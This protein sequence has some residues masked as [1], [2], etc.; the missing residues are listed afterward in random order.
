MPRVRRRPVPIAIWS[1]V[2]SAGTRRHDAAV[3]GRARG[4]CRSRPCGTRAARPARGSVL[5]RSGFR[6]HTRSRIAIAVS[7]SPFAAASACMNSDG[8]DRR[9]ADAEEAQDHGGPIAV[10]QLGGA[11]ARAE[12]AERLALRRASPCRRERARRARRAGPD[13][14]VEARRPEASVRGYTDRAGC[15]RPGGRVVLGAWGSTG[16]WSSR[17]HSS[18]RAPVRRSPGDEVRCSRGRRPA[19]RP[20]WRYR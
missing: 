19:W 1:Q 7:S 20:A 17:G 14:W 3:R 2:S 10:P 15:R 4:A 13:R 5:P 12:L 9:A 11:Q 18:V 8:I 16:C 6:C